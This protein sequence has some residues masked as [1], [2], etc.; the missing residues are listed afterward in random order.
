M[1]QKYE[2]LDDADVHVFFQEFKSQMK[3]SDIQSTGVVDFL[4]GT[5]C[6][7]LFKFL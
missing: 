2:N 4:K 3:S 6:N 1:E 5:A 7:C